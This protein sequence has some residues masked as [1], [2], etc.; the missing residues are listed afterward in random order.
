MHRRTKV[1]SPTDSATATLYQLSVHDF[2]VNVA[3]SKLLA[4]FVRYIMAEFHFR[5]MEARQGKTD[6]TNRFGDR[7]FVLAVCT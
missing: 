3:V 5:S 4:I 7:D 2:F 1:T 6:V